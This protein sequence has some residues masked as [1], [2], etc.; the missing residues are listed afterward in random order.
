MNK[1]VV[2]LLKNEELIR[3]QHPYWIWESIHEIPEMLSACMAEDQTAAVHQAAAAC[4]KKE[5]ETIYLLG[6]GSSYFLTLAGKPL[7]EHL[8][9]IPSFSSVTNVFA[10]YQMEL[11]NSSS[12][13]ILNSHSGKTGEDLD[14]IRQAKELG[15]TTM[16]VTDY[17]DSP[18]GEIVDFV[19]TG[20]GGAKVELPATRSYATTLYLLHKFSTALARKTKAATSASSYDSALAKLPNQIGERMEKAEAVCKIAAEKLSG[21]SSYIVIGYGPNYATADEA[22]LS[23]SQSTAVPAF[24]FELENFIH[25]PIQAL[26]PTQTVICIAPDGALQD[27]MLRTMRAVSTIGA[28]TVLLAPEDQTGLPS[29][30]VK[31]DLP[32][33]VPEL[34]SPLAAMVPLWQFAYQ[35]ALLGGGGHPDRLAMDRPEFQEAFTHLM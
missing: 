14:I 33:G 12:L 10:A 1:D 30:D 20:P 7:L 21:S 28:K 32:A 9:G 8:T 15:A 29:S 24:S 19:L 3:S 17:E 31:I 2:K 13:V 11:I 6:R 5:L 34:V 16:A 18:L 26:T 27:R 22:A 4:A 23:I 35:L 25:G